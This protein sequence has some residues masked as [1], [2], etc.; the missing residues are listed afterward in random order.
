MGAY[1]LQPFMDGL[2]ADDGQDCRFPLLVPIH[3]IAGFQFCAVVDGL[4]AGSLGPC[5]DF[6]Y[7]QP[8]RPG[9]IQKGL[10]R[11][12]IGHDSRPF[13]GVHALPYRRGSAIWF[14]HEIV[15]LYPLASDHKPIT[16]KG[17][18]KK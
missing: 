5:Q 9:C 15:L 8:L 4:E 17:A 10:I 2:F 12:S 3:F 7:G 13:L 6:L 14:F 11:F 16:M 18:V 1:D